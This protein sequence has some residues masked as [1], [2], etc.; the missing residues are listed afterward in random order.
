MYG[1]GLQQGLVLVSDELTLSP[2]ADIA[3]AEGPRK[4]MPEAVLLSASG[5]S[6]TSEAWPLQA[7]RCSLLTSPQLVNAPFSSARLQF[8]GA[9][10]LSYTTPG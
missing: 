9:D 1:A 3:A 7:G 10:R 4:R 8:P 2:R 5:R 6:G